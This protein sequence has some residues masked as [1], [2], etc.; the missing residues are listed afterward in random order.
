MWLS[1]DAEGNQQVE[2]TVG[3][4]PHHQ[5]GTS[6]VPQGTHLRHGSPT[7]AAA[8]AYRYAKNKP[9]VHNRPVCDTGQGTLLAP[10]KKKHCRSLSVPA[11]TPPMATS[12]QVEGARVWRP[13][14]IAAMTTPHNAA[15]LDNRNLTHA[16]PAPFHDART[17]SS[18]TAVG[19][20][21]TASRFHRDFKV[22]GHHPS[23]L[24]GCPRVPVAPSPLSVDSGRETTSDLQT[25]PCSPVPR[26]S[27]ATSVCSHAS[28]CFSASWLDSSPGR[29]RSE[30]LQS[31]SLSCEEQISTGFAAGC[32]STPSFVGAGSVP[33]SPCRSKI[34]R[35]HSQPCV[36][37]DRRCGK[38]RR[39]DSDRPTLDFHKMTEVRGLGRSFYYS[40]WNVVC[41][42]LHIISS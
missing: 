34:P 29:L 23:A 10:P 21:G 17:F 42:L 33:L 7:G 37:H 9:L 2:R 27:S 15:V 8:G 39:R 16:F 32:G 19:T 38:K 18:F 26:P 20:S 25:P 13:I 36:L 11:D 3:S 40:L 28:S 14:P 1:L 12:P 41:L 4:P 6:P 22:P 30:V 35:C 24:C 31:R 5:P